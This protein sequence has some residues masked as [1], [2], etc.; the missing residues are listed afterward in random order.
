MTLTF[1]AVSLSYASGAASEVETASPFYDAFVAELDR[2]PASSAARIVGNPAALERLAA[3]L[4]AESKLAEHAEVVGVADTPSVAARVA[5]AREEE[6]AEAVI[7]WKRKQ[8]ALSTPDMST[9]AKE[10]FLANPDSFSAGTVVRATIAKAR[11]K[12]NQK[13]GQADRAADLA[14]EID[15]FRGASSRGEA[16][17]LIDELRR[18]GVLAEVEEAEAAPLRSFKEPFHSTISRILREG[19]V[20]DAVLYGDRVYLIALGESAQAG[21]PDFE[22]VEAG[23]VRRLEREY[24]SS[25]LAEWIKTVV[26]SGAGEISGEEL[27]RLQ[28]AL[29]ERYIPKFSN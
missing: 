20:A 2:H 1:A 7:E 25:R 28:E 14:E 18:E 23:I 6:L 9:R 13:E 4:Q 21:A 8:L 12:E 27:S 11:V 24:V 15:A 26:G 29:R 10:R 3:Q 17:A 22:A 19:R 5:R 16:L